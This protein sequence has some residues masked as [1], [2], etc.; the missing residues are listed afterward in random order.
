MN[1]T[2][3]L[4]RAAKRQRG[5]L[6]VFAAIL[7]LFLITVLILYAARSSLVDQRI[8]ANEHRYEIS[9]NI[10][11]AASSLVTEAVLAYGTD[12]TSSTGWRDATNGLWST[13]P[14]DTPT[15]PAADA[16]T[17]CNAEPFNT[18]IKAGLDPTDIFFIDDLGGELPRIQDAI[19]QLAAN[20]PN[21]TG[22]VSVGMSFVEAGGVFV[23]PPSPTEEIESRA[24]FMIYAYGY[25]DCQDV[26]DVSTCQG[27]ASVVQ[28]LATARALGGNPD[29]PLVSK[30]TFPPNGTIEIAGNPN[31]GGTGVTATAWLNARDGTVNGPDD[32]A[33]PGPGVASSGSWQTCELQEWYSTDALPD[34]ETCPANGGCVCGD[35]GNDVSDF[36]SYRTSDTVINEDILEDPLFPCDLF[37]LYF[38]VPKDE[39]GLIKSTAV[40]VED[41][42][43]N[44]YFDSESGGQIYWIT[45]EDNNNGECNLNPSGTD[46]GSPDKPVI[47]V[48]TARDTRLNANTRLFGILYIFDYVDPPANVVGN[49]GPELYGSLIVDGN[50]DNF[51]GNIAV[52]Y[53][54]GILA[55]AAGIGGFAAAE[56]GW[57]DYDVPAYNG[58]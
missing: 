47:I 11:E 21:A 33:G 10:A 1:V 18:A 45:D 9:F 34:D 27:E 41:S 50:M 7:I 52:V 42:D 19:D 20:N 28:P 46:I 24:L 32:C 17:P 57:R 51:T 54:E 38:G 14:A 36:L 53:T 43:C 8:S 37:E 40:K 44:G 30:S 35:G 4:T 25:S 56:G 23:G 31:A 12:V 3:N 6:T 22:R 26:T 48:S 55:R 15:D 29:V 49:G 2:S 5:A 16:I 13:C 39:Y 58:N